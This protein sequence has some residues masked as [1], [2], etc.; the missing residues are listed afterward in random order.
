MLAVLGRFPA[1]QEGGKASA[2]DGS[3]VRV[4]AVPRAGGMIQQIAHAFKI[5]AGRQIDS[6]GAPG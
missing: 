1:D 2:A 3:A 6:F 5:I 4:G